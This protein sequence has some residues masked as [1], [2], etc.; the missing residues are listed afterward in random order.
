MISL[1]ERS[2]VREI[3]TGTLNEQSEFSVIVE[4]RDHFFV[5]KETTMTEK[6]LPILRSLLSNCP[7]TI[8][9]LSNAAAFLYEQL[10]DV[11]WAGFYLVDEKGDL[12]LGPF[13]GKVACVSISAG[14][15]VCGTSLSEKRTV[16]VPDVSLFPGYISCDADARSELVI[17][18]K[19]NEGNIIAVL[20]IDSGSK[21]RFSEDETK[22]SE[23]NILEKAVKIIEEFIL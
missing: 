9:L 7:H 2:E 18:V 17:P 3:G 23:I 6:E 14:K 15:G 21:G 22:I 19:D 16:I 13:Q 4:S 8:S 12:Y 10:D 1:T 5:S 11:C 20:D